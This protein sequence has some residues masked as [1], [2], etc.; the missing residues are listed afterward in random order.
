MKIKYEIKLE[1]YKKRKQE[2]DL[3]LKTKMPKWWYT[4][5]SVKVE[6]ILKWEKPTNVTEIYSFLILTGY[7]RRFIEGFSTIALLMTRLTWKGTK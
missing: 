3:D 2:N 1:Y 5:W 7:Y 6:A 4:C